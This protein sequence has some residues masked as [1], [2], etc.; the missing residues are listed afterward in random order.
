MKDLHFFHSCVV[1]FW[2]HD[3]WQGRLTFVPSSASM[4]TYFHSVLF[5]PSSSALG[6]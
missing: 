4:P 3:S 6:T 5:V 2:E 1:N